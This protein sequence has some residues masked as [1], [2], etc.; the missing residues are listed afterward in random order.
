MRLDIRELARFERWDDQDT[1]ASA[2]GI[3]RANYHMLT[4]R[5]LTPRRADELCTRIGVHP[6]AV[7]GPV[8]ELVE[9]WFLVWGGREGSCPVSL[10]GVS[11][12]PEPE[13]PGWFC[14]RRLEDRGGRLH[15]CAVDGCGCGRTGVRV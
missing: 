6:H 7:W 1:A 14:G 2:C 12:W 3:T 15:R 8:Y 4:K 9:D 10:D 11:P 13:R 5:G